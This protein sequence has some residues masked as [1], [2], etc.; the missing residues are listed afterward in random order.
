MVKAGCVT[1]IL[2]WERIAVLVMI[3]ELVNLV[4][5]TI[6]GFLG[7]TLGAWFVIGLFTATAVTAYSAVQQT[8]AAKEG[9]KLQE[10]QLSAAES[11]AGEYYELSEKQMELQSQQSSIDTLAKLIEDKK[12]SAAPQ[13]FTLPPAREY[14][15]MERMNQAIDDMLRG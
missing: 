14:G 8:K 11:Q 13:I 5:V 15:T 1:A 10:K 7:I 3:E 9:R 12:Q 4:P 2:S 6:L